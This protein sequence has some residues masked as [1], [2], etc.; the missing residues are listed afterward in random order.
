MVMS[1][2]MARITPLD[3]DKDDDEMIV[4]NDGDDKKMT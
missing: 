2:M 4:V 3:C 1:M